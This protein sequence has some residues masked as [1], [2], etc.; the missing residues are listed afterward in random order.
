LIGNIHIIVFVLILFLQIP[1]YG[2]SE[3]DLDFIL[4]QDTSS[5]GKTIRIEQTAGLETSELKFLLNGFIKTYQTLLSS[6]QSPQI[7]TF[8]PSCSHF[9]YCSIRDY[10]PFWGVLM[11][12][13]R[14]ARCHNFNYPYYKFDI[15]SRKLTDPV[16]IYFKGFWWP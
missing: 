13:D 14:F 11:T 16:D 7:C 1:S 6:Q 9:G 4:S 10:G 12:S 2:Q 8:K 5:R 15:H 3:R